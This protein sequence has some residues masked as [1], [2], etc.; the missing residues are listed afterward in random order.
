MKARAIIPILLLFTLSLL[1]LNKTSAQEFKDQLTP[2]ELLDNIITKDFKKETAR[3]GITGV[4]LVQHLYKFGSAEEKGLKMFETSFDS[5]GNLVQLVLFET[6][7]AIK[8][9]AR[10]KREPDRINPLRFRGKYREKGNF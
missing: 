2:Q 10:Y 5:K 9:S 6:D 7:G 8:I 1:L 3:K 4:S